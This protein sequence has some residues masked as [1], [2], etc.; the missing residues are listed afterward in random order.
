MGEQLVRISELTRQVSRTAQTLRRLERLGRIPSSRR[1]SISGERCWTES[2]AGEIRAL[3][4]IE[5]EDEA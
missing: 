5:A 3:F 4:G 1:S 2:E